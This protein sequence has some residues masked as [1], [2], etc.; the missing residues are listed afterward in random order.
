MGRRLGEGVVV[1]S[2]D[3]AG[4]EVT[5]TAWRRGEEDRPHRFIAQFSDD[6][7]VTRWRLVEEPGT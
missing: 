5:G 7:V 4:N 1:R 6:G 2:D 3:V